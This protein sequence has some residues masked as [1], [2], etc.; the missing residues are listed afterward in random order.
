MEI[1]QQIKYKH[2]I[3]LIK[4]DHMYLYVRKV[5]DIDSR[6]QKNSNFHP[7]KILYSDVKTKH[8]LF[9]SVLLFTYDLLHL[10]T[11]MY[12]SVK[13]KR[14]LYVESIFFATSPIFSIRQET[15][16]FL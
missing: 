16:S 9:T 2:S 13:N 1:I 11:K 12:S 14:K 8:Y 15:V 7:H 5:I 6:E 4:K 10:L 3:T